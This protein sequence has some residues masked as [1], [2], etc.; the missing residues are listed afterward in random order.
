MR[1]NFQIL[2]ARLVQFVDGDG[3]WLPNPHGKW[4]IVCDASDFAVGGVLKQQQSPQDEQS[5]RPVAFYSRKLQGQ[6]VDGVN[7]HR[8]L[9]QI[10]W[11]PR[12][13]E[14]YA[15]V[16]CLLEFQSWIG[17]QEVMVQTDHSAVVKWYN[18]EL[19]TISGP[20]GR[21]GRWHEFLSRFNLFIQYR[22]GKDNEAADAL[23]RWG[24]ATGRCGD[25]HR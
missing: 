1:D 18:G 16:T 9:G 4:R 8:K 25:T 7:F 22:P 19:T 23:S 15:I 11:T 13:K 21:R 14:T 24:P 2:K 20:L 3:L 5:W 17:S 6:R 10:A 12:E